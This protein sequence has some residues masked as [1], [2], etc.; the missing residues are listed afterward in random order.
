VICRP[1]FASH[2]A[3]S[4]VKGADPISYG[5]KYRVTNSIGDGSDIS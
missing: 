3:R 4:L 2:S 1:S 5:Q